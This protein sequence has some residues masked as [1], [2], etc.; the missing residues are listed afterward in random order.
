MTQKLPILVFIEMYTKCINM[1]IQSIE[2]CWAIHND[3]LLWY[4]LFFG[5]KL[6]IC[7]C[8][9]GLLLFCSAFL[10]KTGSLQ[11][12]SDKVLKAKW[13]HWTY[14]N[15]MFLSNLDFIIGFAIKTSIFTHTHTHTHTHS[16][17]TFLYLINSFYRRYAS[18]VYNRSNRLTRFKRLNFFVVLFYV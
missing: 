12:V 8:C 11:H 17:F 6:H 18:S 4:D 13:P 2:M 10:I 16:P 14:R 9:I 5:V 3:L 7:G 1:V 15:I